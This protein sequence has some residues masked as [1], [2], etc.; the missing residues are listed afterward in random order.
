MAHIFK[1]PTESNKGIIVFTHKEWPW[2]LQNAQSTLNDL[3]QYYYLGWN[4][5]IYFGNIPQMPLQVDFTFSSPTAM[6]YP[7]NG[8]TLKIEGTPWCVA[9]RGWCC[10]ERHSGRQGR[11]EA[12]ADVQ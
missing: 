7:D 6:D 12:Q 9:K 11:I 1:Y 5:G 10:M 3:K 4:Q 2:L 8:H